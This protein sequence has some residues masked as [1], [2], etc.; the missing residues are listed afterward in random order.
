MKV[1]QKWSSV[2]DE[3]IRRSYESVPTKK[4]AVALGR[5]V[6]GVRNRASMLGVRRERPWT[7]DDDRALIR[8]SGSVPD[9]VIAVSLHRTN[10]AVVARRRHLK[11]LGAA[12]RP[13][14]RRGSHE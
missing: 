13:G 10:G 8:M 12:I 3:V 7:A 2:E 1:G 11:A 6:A 4:I 14:L 5:S 9:D